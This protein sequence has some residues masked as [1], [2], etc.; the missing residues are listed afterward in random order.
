MKKA[1]PQRVLLVS[2][3][4]GIAAAVHKRLSDSGFMVQVTDEGGTG[5]AMGNREGYE[6]LCIDVS[7]PGTGLLDVV[8]A[9]AAGGPLPP[10]VMITGPDTTV[11]SLEFLDRGPVWYCQRDADGRYLDVLPYLVRCVISL[12]NSAAKLGGIGNGLNEL[13]AVMRVVFDLT[14]VAMGMIDRAGRWL[15]VNAARCD[16]FGY[17]REELMGLTNRDVTYPDDLDRTDAYI[18]DMIE[19]KADSHRIEKRFV[20]KDGNTVWADVSTTAVRDK[21]NAFVALIGAVMDIGEKKQIE[22]RLLTAQ[23]MEAIGMLAGGIAHDFNN[24]LATIL[25]YASFLKGKATND[26]IFFSGLTAIEDSA[27]RASELTAQILAYTRGKKMEVGTFSVNEIAVDINKLILKTFNKSITIK[28]EQDEDIETID[29]DKVQ[30]KQMLLNLC[31]N[32]RDMMP[33]GGE[34]TIRTCMLR[35]PEDGIGT[36]RTVP[37]GRYVG[38]GVSDTGEGMDEEAR[39][40]VIDSFLSGET[41]AKPAGFGLSV[42]C[43]IAGRHGGWVDAVSRADAGTEFIVFFPVS[44]EKKETRAAKPEVVV[45]GS[46]T[47]LIVDDEIQIVSMLKRLLTDYGY[48]VL[49]A[50]SGADGVRIFEENKKEIGLVLLDIMMPGMGGDRVL[51]KIIR[52]SPKTKVLLASG[53]SEQERYQGLMEMGAAGFIGKPFNVRSL[54]GKIRSILG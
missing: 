54:L 18:A 49:Y 42:V 22:E 38:I 14:G 47:I 44:K 29:G 6:V 40:R 41:G 48:R 15:Q 11:T 43:E 13:E 39:R 25:G 28:L 7:A 23:K 36:G 21:D 17:T 20:R 30:I 35:V 24:V 51:E 27:V 26:D 5:A 4:S 10:T 53:F 9:F 45:G 52:I 1:P 12:G 16:L 33:K 34:L 46:E 50:H 8:R 2:G 3:D 37:P 32:A 19:G 31:I